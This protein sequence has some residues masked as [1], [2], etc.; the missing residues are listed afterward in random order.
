MNDLQK[1]LEDLTLSMKNM[2]A[3]MSVT[4]S[5]ISSLSNA[6]SRLAGP[7][8]ESCERNFTE[9]WS[10][11]ICDKGTCMHCMILQIQLKSTAKEMHEK[12]HHSSID[13]C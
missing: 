10:C 11:G 3:V 7:K 6:Y 2:M 13:V 1:K 4:Q 8:C 5:S 12:N 9:G